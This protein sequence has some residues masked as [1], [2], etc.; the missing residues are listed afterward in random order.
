MK[1]PHSPRNFAGLGESFPQKRDR[2]A[3]QGLRTEKLGGV[4]SFV[5]ET[6][7]FFGWANDDSVEFVISSV[8]S[9]DH[10][11]PIN[12]GDISFRVLESMKC[13]GHRSILTVSRFQITRSNRSFSPYAGRVCRKAPVAALLH[14]QKLERKGAFPRGHRSQ[15]RATERRR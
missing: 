15:R 3:F 10:G 4:Y 8:T 14:Q 5:D 6:G 9:N 13:A 7:R 1:L 2:I 12:D 11:T